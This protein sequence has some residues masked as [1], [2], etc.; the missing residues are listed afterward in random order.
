MSGAKLMSYLSVTLVVAFLLSG[1][2]EYFGGNNRIAHFN[3]RVPS[4]SRGR[5]AAETERVTRMVDKIARQ[6][7]FKL[8]SRERI[9]EIVWVIPGEPNY[10]GEPLPGQPDVVSDTGRFWY[11]RVDRPDGIPDRISCDVWPPRI[12]NVLQIIMW[13]DYA[14]KMPPPAEA[15]WA[16]LVAG[17][18]NLYG[19]EAIIEIED[20]KK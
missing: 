5:V 1:C 20:L 6:H 19:R 2:A 10:H 3:V 11:L 4:S 17:V 14:S 13:V 9:G 18:T 12:G 7:G 8:G 16:D 15:L